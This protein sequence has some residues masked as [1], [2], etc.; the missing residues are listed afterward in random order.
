MRA[1]LWLVVVALGDGSCRLEEVGGVGRLVLSFMV[2]DT[3]MEAEFWKG[4]L[5]GGW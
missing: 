5:D 3:V 2:R 4:G 1:L